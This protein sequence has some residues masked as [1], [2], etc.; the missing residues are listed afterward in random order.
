MHGVVLSSTLLRYYQ[1]GV[2]P[3]PPRRLGTLAR[4]LLTLAMHGRHRA[5]VSWSSAAA[6]SA[7]IRLASATPIPQR[8]AAGGR[9]AAPAQARI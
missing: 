9:L 8:P 6:V 7:A 1:T 5:A 4:Y 2:L 3:P